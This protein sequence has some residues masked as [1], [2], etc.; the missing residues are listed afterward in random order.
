MKRI[1]VQIASYRDEL[2]LP[3]IQSA[4]SNAKHPNRLFFGICLQDERKAIA[5]LKKIPHVSIH[6]LNYNKSEG[7]G[8][9]RAQAQK[10]Y[11]GEEYVLQTDSHMQFEPNWDFN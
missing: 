2:L 7:V 8:W 9:A 10:L 1:F 3:T 4:I 5:T 6:F 11:Q